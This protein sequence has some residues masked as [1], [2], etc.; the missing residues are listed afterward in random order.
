MGIARRGPSGQ[1]QT[2][3][4]IAHALDAASPADIET[5]AR[6]FDEAR[7]GLRAIAES[8]DSALGEL[9]DAWRSTQATVVRL[10]EPSRRTRQLVHS[11][12]DAE[13]GQQ[14]RVTATALGVGQARVRD[15]QVQRAADSGPSEDEWDRR[16]RIVLQGLSETYRD[17]GLGLGGQDPPTAETVDEPGIRQ[18]LSAARDDPSGVVLAADSAA[19]DLF[20]P[21]APTIRAGQPG[22]AA[23][24]PSG[25]GGG[26]GGGGLPMMPLMPMGGMGGGMGGMGGGMGGMGGEAGGQRRGSTLAQGDPTVWKDADAGWNVLGR[27][28]RIDEHIREGLRKEL[29]DA[30]KG[31]RNG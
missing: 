22:D 24:A 14:L 8:F 30:R 27:G 28:E 5:S 20:R 31:D 21:A 9:D 26:A 13:C 12:D 7:S 11:L 16:A 3:R 25:G 19:A 29:G 15:L 10:G 6:L 4:D 18:A 1:P 17:V 23:A 2:L